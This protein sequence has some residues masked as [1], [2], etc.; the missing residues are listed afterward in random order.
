MI[1]TIYGD[2]G[3]YAASKGAYTALVRRAGVR[4]LL[5]CLL[6]FRLRGSGFQVLASRRYLYMMVNRG[7]G[8]INN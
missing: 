5:G 1:C 6:S 2:R 4:V 8:R 7:Q 3:A